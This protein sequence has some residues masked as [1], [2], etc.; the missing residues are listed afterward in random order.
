[1]AGNEKAMKLEDAKPCTTR[2][3][4]VAISGIPDRE[5][6]VPCI[7]GWLDLLER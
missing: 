7:F 5:A 3:L 1:M 4:G 6:L 2:L